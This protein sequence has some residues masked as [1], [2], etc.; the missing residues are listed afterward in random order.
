MK[1]NLTFHNLC[2]KTNKKL[3]YQ[4]IVKVKEISSL[5]QWASDRLQ[6]M[7]LKSSIIDT[8]EVAMAGG[9]RIIINY[10]GI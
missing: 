2:N 5:Y 6:L 3:F 7:T 8:K 9:C 1:Q 4:K 10:F